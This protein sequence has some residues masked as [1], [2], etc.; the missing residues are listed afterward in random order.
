MAKIVSRQY[1]YNKTL[2]TAN[3]E[4]SQQLPAWA[5][6]F[7]IQCRTAYDVRIAFTSGKVAV[8]TE[9][10]WTIVAEDN[11]SQHNMCEPKD[12]PTTIYIA[13]STAGVVVE[14]WVSA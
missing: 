9:P 1:I 14:I 3:T 7:V 4:Y 12:V 5:K 8:P 10:Y 6:E 13:S 2:T 11:A